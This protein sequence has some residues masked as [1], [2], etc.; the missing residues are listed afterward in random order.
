MA[1]RWVQRDLMRT[2]RS[3][4]LSQYL[5]SLTK[6][7]VLKP[8]NLSRSTHKACPPLFWTSM[9]GTRAALAVTWLSHSSQYIFCPGVV[10]YPKKHSGFLDTLSWQLLRSFTH[11]METEKH[12]C[13][14]A[15][16]KKKKGKK[17]KEEG[18]SSLNHVLYCGGTNAAC[19]DPPDKVFTRTVLDSDHLNP[20]RL[21]LPYWLAASCW[22]LRA[23]FDVA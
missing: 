3:H 1:C 18:V 13:S 14:F 17:K 22:E 19:K 6:N 2:I 7:L 8:S 9:H 12:K 16:L 11:T 5:P 21:K 10:S 4:R 23:S 15:W 20:K